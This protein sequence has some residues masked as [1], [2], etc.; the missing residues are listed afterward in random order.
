MSQLTQLEVPPSC[1]LDLASKPT[2]AHDKLSLENEEHYYPISTMRPIK[3]I[4]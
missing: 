4:V 1:T 3:I 2:Q